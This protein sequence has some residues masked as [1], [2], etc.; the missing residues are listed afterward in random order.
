MGKGKKSSKLDARQ[1]ATASSPSF[2][3]HSTRAE[4]YAMGKSDAFDEAVAA[5]SVAYADQN[6]QDHAALKRAIVD[7]KIEALVEEP[8]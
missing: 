1:P 4:R 6:E 3:S 7:G 8:K 5:L 2:K